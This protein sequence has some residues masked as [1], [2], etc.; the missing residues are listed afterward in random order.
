MTSRNAAAAN[1]RSFCLASHP[2]DF[3]MPSRIF[4]I[5]F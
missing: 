2:Y 4:H 1:R 5:D 3:L